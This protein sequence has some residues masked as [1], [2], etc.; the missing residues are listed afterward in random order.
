MP[1]PCRA[2]AASFYDV[3]NNRVR[4]STTLGHIAGTLGGYIASHEYGHAIHRTLGTLPTNQDAS[5]QIH[6]FDS[7][8]LVDCAWREG[9]ANF[10]S[11]ALLGARMGNPALWEINNYYVPGQDGART[12]GPIASFCSASV[13]M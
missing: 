10:M 9:F 11:V 2:Y 6:G 4:V 13:E 8:E 1:H 7:L 5:C 12:E 3:T